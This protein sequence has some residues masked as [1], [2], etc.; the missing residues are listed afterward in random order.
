MLIL[1]IVLIIHSNFSIYYFADFTAESPYN[2]KPDLIFN[3]WSSGLACSPN[4]ISALFWHKEICHS[5]NKGFLDKMYL[6][7]YV[8][9]MS[10][11]ICD[12]HFF[13]LAPSLYL[14]NNL[15]TELWLKIELIW[16]HRDYSS[17]IM[18]LVY[19]YLSWFVN[20]LLFN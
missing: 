3:K 9:Y 17:N 8:K 12:I 7:A 18:L 13:L 16:T 15:P 4:I 14:V 6:F 20:N 19:S 10:L 2:I 11:S 5:Y 1:Q